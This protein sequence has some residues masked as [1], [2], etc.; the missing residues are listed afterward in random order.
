MSTSLCPNCNCPTVEALNPLSNTDAVNYYRCTTCAHVWNT[1][2]AA[3][4]AEPITVMSGRDVE[5]C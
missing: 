3:P 2:K 4:D 5:K 1:P